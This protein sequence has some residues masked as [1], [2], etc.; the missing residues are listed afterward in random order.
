[1]TNKLPQLRQILTDNKIKGYS[2]YNKPQ[3]V[4]LLRERQL[5]PLEVEKLTKPK[6]EIDPRF[7]RLRTIRNNS[8]HVVLKDIVT[9]EEFKF[10]SIYRAGQFINK[11]PRTITFW[12]GRI[13]NKKYLIKIVEGEES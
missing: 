4:E 7:E 9:E 6:K 11:A 10:S 2:H 5:L 8:K 3:L 13:W 12:G 1:M